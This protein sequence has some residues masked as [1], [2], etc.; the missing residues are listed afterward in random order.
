MDRR[1]FILNSALGAAGLASGRLGGTSGLHRPGHLDTPTPDVAA[2]LDRFDQGVGRIEDWSISSSF[3]D[4]QGDAFLLD[5]LGRKSM[6]TLYATGMFCDLPIECQVHPGMQDRMWAIQPAMDESIAGITNLL[7]RQAPRDLAR[8]Q[9][10]LRERPAFVSQVTETLDAEAA[11][12]GLSDARRHQFRTQMMQVEWRL[13]HQPPG[14]LVNEYLVKVDKVAASDIQAEARQ[15]WLA[16]KMGERAFWQVE[17]TKRQRRISRGLRTMGI[18]V[19]ILGASAVLVAATA[20]GGG[21]GVGIGLFGA[22][23]GSIFILVGLI[24]LLVG[25]GTPSGAT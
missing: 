9:S 12:S 20:D 25:L 10:A 1:D 19:L 14:L 23:V 21:A 16:A 8:V 22:T 2:Y 6:K 17:R 15:R 4:F 24:I 7:G 3:P 13:Q 18:G 11:R 5:S